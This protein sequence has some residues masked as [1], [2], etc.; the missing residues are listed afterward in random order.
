M[1]A[2]ERR[3]RALLDLELQDS[4]RKSA[5][6]RKAEEAAAMALEDLAMQERTR[7]E[8]AQFTERKEMGLEDALSRKWEAILRQAGQVLVLFWQNTEGDNEWCKCRPDGGRVALGSSY[9]RAYGKRE[10]EVH[11]PCGF[12]WG[13]DCDKYSALSV[14][15]GDSSVVFWVYRGRHS[16]LC[17]SV[18]P[19]IN[20]GIS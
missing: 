2:E 5:A 4:Q 19:T 10:G 3:T 14:M 16:N 1:R 8:R 18:T 17:H 7:Q 6:R 15:D 13:V 20:A 12:F 9:S 11:T